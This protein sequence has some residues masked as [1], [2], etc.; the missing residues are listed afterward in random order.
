MTILPFI[1]LGMGIIGGLFVTAP[2]FTSASEKV[3]TVA[4]IFLMLSIGVGIQAV[5]GFKG[6][7][8]N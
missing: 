5:F 7:W 3:S 8:R 6:V 4:L 2:K 1:C